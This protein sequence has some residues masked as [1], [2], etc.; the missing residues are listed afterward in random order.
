MSLFDPFDSPFLFVFSLFQ[1]YLDFPD[2][3]FVVLLPQIVDDGQT[4]LTELLFKLILQPSHNLLVPAHLI[5]FLS[6]PLLQ[7]R[8][9]FHLHLIQ[10][11][12]V[13][14]VVV[15]KQLF[16][17]TELVQVVLDILAVRLVI[18]QSFPH[19]FAEFLH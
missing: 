5:F 19:E 9:F 14:A 10:F 3:V 12:V 6:K 15:P 1:S 13:F 18:D 11:F 8:Q 7:Q 16:H 17:S 4:V 2:V